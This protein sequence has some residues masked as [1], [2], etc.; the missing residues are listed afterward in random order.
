V[1]QLR[2]AGTS[3]LWP[4]FRQARRAAV[5]DAVP[6][7]VATGLTLLGLLWFAGRHERRHETWEIAALSLALIPIFLQLTCYYYVFVIV[8]AALAERRPIAGAVLLAMCAGSMAIALGLMPRVGMDE[9]CV[10]LSIV[11]V[12]GLGATL[13]LVLRT[14]HPGCCAQRIRRSA[15]PSIDAR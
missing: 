7:I 5:R 3:D 1:Q 11:S 2:E 14:H 10:A 12:L 8:W 9:T 15:A 4:R 6:V 13:A